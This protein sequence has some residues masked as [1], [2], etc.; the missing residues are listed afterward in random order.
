MDGGVSVF[1]NGLSEWMVESRSGWLSVE[2]FGQESFG[3]GQKWMQ[4]WM[5]ESSVFRYGVS[6]HGWFGWL[7]WY[8]GLSV[9]WCFGLLVCLSQAE[10]S[11]S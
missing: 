5:V 7:S 6:K 8:F 1:R 11:I 4:Q 9:F 3:N 10:F 2:C